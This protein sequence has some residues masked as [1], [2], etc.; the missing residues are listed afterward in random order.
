MD[1]KMSNMASSSFKIKAINDSLVLTHKHSSD[2]KLKE[3]QINIA[4]EVSE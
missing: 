3:Q 4:N 2:R 1:I